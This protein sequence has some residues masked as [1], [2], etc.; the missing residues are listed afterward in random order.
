MRKEPTPYNCEEFPWVKLSV[1]AKQD[2]IVKTSDYLDK[3]KLPAAYDIALALIIKVCGP[4]PLTAE[5]TEDGKPPEK[6]KPGRPP[7]HGH[8]CGKR[9]KVKSEET[10]DPDD[11]ES[12]PKDTGETGAVKAPTAASKVVLRSSPPIR[13]VP[14]KVVPGSSPPTRVVHRL[15]FH[16]ASSPLKAKGP[17]NFRRAVAGSGPIAGRK[18]ALCVPSPGPSAQ[19]NRTKDSEEPTLPDDIQRASDGIRWRSETAI[20]LTTPVKVPAK[21]PTPARKAK[22]ATKSPVQQPIVEVIRTEDEAGADNGT[23]VEEPGSEDPSDF[24]FSG[25]SDEEDDGLLA[26]EEEVETYNLSVNGKM[27]D[28]GSDDEMDIDV[29]ADPVEEDVAMENEQGEE[30]QQDEEQQNEEEQD[31][32]EQDEEEQDEE[33]QDKELSEHH[34]LSERNELSEHE[35]VTVTVK[36]NKTADEEPMPIPPPKPRAGKKKAVEV[37][38]V[39]RRSNRVQ[40]RTEKQ[41]MAKPSPGL[42]TSSDA[43]IGVIPTSESDYCPTTKA[44]AKRGKK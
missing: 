5:P 40:L 11:D 7:T 19:P 43:T 39:R 41:A 24:Q 1:S 33:Q 29:E 10:V 27:P 36:Q 32:E 8:N 14:G 22:T 28:Q 18:S 17:P 25:E 30:E 31:E 13:A 23:V 44:K 21:R 34:E 42:M 35:E 4:P 6:R 20:D 15:E 16:E 2:Q 3:Y 9:R 26:G 37:K 38:P 12:Q